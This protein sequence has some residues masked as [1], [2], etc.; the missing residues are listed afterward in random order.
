[1]LLK[2]QINKESVNQMANRKN[3][4]EGLTIIIAEDNPAL[5]NNMAFLLELAGLNVLK[6]HDGAEAL[7]L[8]ETTTPDVIVSDIKMPHV[9]GYELLHHVRS[10]YRLGAVP[11][12]VISDQYGL[13]DLT[14]ALDMGATDYIPKPFDIYDVLDSVY[15]SLTRTN[16][17]VLAAVS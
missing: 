10:D 8:L 14:L 2:G 9:D 1:M 12:I 3:F 5:L 11:F 13:N 4:L 6:A 7:A 15:Q 16:V 17:P